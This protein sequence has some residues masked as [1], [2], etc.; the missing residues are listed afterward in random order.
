MIKNACPMRM[1]RT[2][3]EGGMKRWREREAGL[4]ALRVGEAEM[5][6]VK[7]MLFTT[8]ESERSGWR[9]ERRQRE[10]R[11]GG[12]LALLFWLCPSH[13]VWMATLEERGDVVVCWVAPALSPLPVWWRE[14]CMFSCVGS[15]FSEVCIALILSRGYWLSVLCFLIDHSILILC[16]CSPM[17]SSH[18]SDSTYFC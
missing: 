2:K 16:S 14:L 11:V 9:R 3:K 4:S 15:P 17:F 6:S 8:T 18:K 7:R 10:A 5:R 13:A 1:K 12:V